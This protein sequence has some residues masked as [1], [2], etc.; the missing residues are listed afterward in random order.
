[1]KRERRC[2]AKTHEHIRK[3]GEREG[4]AATERNFERTGVCELPEYVAHGVM[5]PQ[6]LALRIAG[7]KRARE[8]ARITD[9]E[10]HGARR[11]SP[12][13]PRGFA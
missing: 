12:K 13:V 1:V 10:H 11:S 4:L 9:S 6:T 7:T 5:R 3:P 2:V 8:I